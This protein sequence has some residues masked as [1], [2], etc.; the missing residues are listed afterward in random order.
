MRLAPGSGAPWLY[1]ASGATSSVSGGQF[2]TA[3]GGG[4]SVSGGEAN[5]AGGFV[6]SVSGNFSVTQSNSGGW[7]GGSTGAVVSGSFSSP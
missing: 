3:S 4:S 5:T 6:S 1:I 7:S 2:N